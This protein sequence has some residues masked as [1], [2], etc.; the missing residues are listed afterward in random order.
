MSTTEIASRP[1]PAP[2]QAPAVP[3]EERHVMRDAPWNLYDRLTDALGEHSPFRVAY[4]GKDMEIMTLGPKHERSKG[5]LGLFI[6]YVLT[7]LE[8][9]CEELR[10]T[11]W[12]RPELE[13]GIEADLCYCFD[14]SKIAAIRAAIARDSNDVAEYPNPDLAVE[15]DVSPSKI[16]RPGIY[17]AL[18]VSEVWRLHDG[19]VSID[20]I[21]AG[22]SYVAAE[23]SRFLYIRPDEVTR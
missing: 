4:D 18:R 2:S 12:K 16:D 14:P 17:F 20:Q 6:E 21:G 23:S 11:T 1:N 7:G 15:I 9:E 22:G 8:I 5:L 13:R 3:G 19:N 10:S